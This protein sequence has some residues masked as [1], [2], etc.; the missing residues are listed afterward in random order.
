MIGYAAKEIS[1]IPSP[2]TDNFVLLLVLYIFSKWCE[3]CENSKDV[4]EDYGFLCLLAAY[5]ITIKL[6][7]AML[8]VLV[9][10]PVYELIKNR[11]FRAISCFIFMGLLIVVPYLLRSFVLSGY[12]VYP[13]EMTGFLNVDWKVPESIVK[14]ENLEITS[15]AR[16]YF[17]VEQFEMVNAM[18][19][20]EWLPTWWNMQTL[21]IKIMSV[22]NLIGCPC[23]VILSI[24]N[25]L[26]KRTNYDICV[27]LT[28]MVQYLY[29]MLSAPKS[30][31]G[32]VFLF[33][34][35]G[36]VL[37]LVLER[38]NKCSSWKYGSGLFISGVLLVALLIN[39]VKV[40]EKVP[41]KRSSY[42]VYRDT[43]EVDWNG[44][45]VYIPIENNNTGYYGF[46]GAT[47]E[48]ILQ[49]IELREDTIEAGIRF[50]PEY[51]NIK[52]MDD[53]RVWE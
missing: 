42:Y 20:L 49:Y 47:Y 12:F 11:K 31:Y 34:I 50:K 2:N 17:E 48:N 28:A 27:M 16:G 23:L 32:I 40:I 38:F 41:I 10:R 6:S 15:R 30:R 39:S 52:L 14:F 45:T 51:N 46:P 19:F 5:A 22:L 25:S 1:L 36:M 3:Y 18:S 44:M 4:V 24:Y 21:I 35:P 37:A 7:V 43:R 8:A 9:L 29:W 13:S 53:G 26:K 33:L